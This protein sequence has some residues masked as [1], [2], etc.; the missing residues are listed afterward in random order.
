[1]K[2]TSYVWFYLM[3]LFCLWPNTMAEAAEPAWVLPLRQLLPP[4]KLQRIS[5]NARTPGWRLS[6]N[7]RS[8]VESYT[9]LVHLDA[10]GEEPISLRLYDRTGRFVRD[11]TYPRFYFILGF[12]WEPM[13]NSLIFTTD[14]LNN[15]VG[16]W[17][18]DLQTGRVSPYQYPDVSPSRYPDMF[19]HA[20]PTPPVASVSPS[21]SPSLRQYSHPFGSPPRT[22]PPVASVSLSI[23]RSFLQWSLNGESYLATVTKN[24]PSSDTPLPAPLS[25]LLLEPLD[26]TILYCIQTRSGLRHK[27]AQKNFFSAC[28][29]PDGQRVLLQRKFTVVPRTPTSPSDMYE[30]W[31][32]KKDGS[33]EVPLIVRSQERRLAALHHGVDPNIGG[34]IG[35]CG[36]N[37]VLTNGGFMPEQE[38]RAI[39][40]IWVAR[41]GG[42][43][44]FVPGVSLVS[45]S[46][47]GRSF[48]FQED[49][50]NR[51]KGYL[52]TLR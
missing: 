30:L 36:P 21:V 24:H 14:F 32:I 17:Q 50:G 52:I 16:T 33:G 46:Q 31:V 49:H 47:D 39:D 10:G 22:G 7:G 40:G 28:Y 35:W 41:I 38:G 27:L 44:V 11:L 9:H 37:I 34:S 15:E 2:P 12:D 3:L 48:L 5:V 8:I 25:E 43:V 18:C 29:S 20:A 19:S 4:F 1:M 42:R 45:A 6:P 51:G 26:D 13:K 23:S